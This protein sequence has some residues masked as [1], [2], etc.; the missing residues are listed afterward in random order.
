M[1]YI[2][3]LGLSVSFVALS[4]PMLWTIFCNFYYI[5]L[6]LFVFPLKLLLDDVGSVICCIKRFV[7]V[8]C[9]FGTGV[10]SLHLIFFYAIH[11]IT[12][13]YLCFVTED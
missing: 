1:R 9:S 11:G 8:I 10:V 13:L 2:S 3:I 12:G 6:G 5:C 7:Y 4:C